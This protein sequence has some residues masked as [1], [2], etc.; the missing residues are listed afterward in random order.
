MHRRRFFHWCSILLTGC[1]A[2]LVAI[3]GVGF[4][5]DPLSRR[6]KR[7]RWRRLLKVADLE[8]GVPRKLVITDRRVDA[9]TRYPEGSI[10]AVWLIRRDEQTVDAF[11]TTCPHLGCPVEHVAAEQKFFCPC[12]EAS[13]GED[14]SILVG[15]QQR[16]LDQLEV[17]YDAVGEESWVSVVFEGFELGI[18][19]KVSLG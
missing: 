19:Q 2:A 11:S 5:I 14:G 12:H 8:I 7:R 9:W 3:P 13:Y 17:R 15:P 18:S 16:G 1:A 10:G 4:V 6:Q